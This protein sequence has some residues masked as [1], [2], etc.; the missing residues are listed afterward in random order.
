LFGIHASYEPLLN[1]N[2]GVVWRLNGSDLPFII[3]DGTGT[4]GSGG[5]PDETAGSFNRMLIPGFTAAQL[6]VGAEFDDYFRISYGIIGTA[7]IH[8]EMHLV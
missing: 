6:V 7:Q 8:M 5:E 1:R 3:D 2:S 4:P